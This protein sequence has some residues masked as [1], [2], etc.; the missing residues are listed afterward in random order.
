QSTDD[1][2]DRR[3]EAAA[4]EKE[5]E[6]QEGEHEP[7]MAPA[8]EDDGPDE[9]NAPQ[10]YRSDAGQREAREDAH[11]RLASVPNLVGRTRRTDRWEHKSR[12]RDV[13]ALDLEVAMLEFVER[14]SP[15]NHAPS[16]RSALPIGSPPPLHRDSRT[17]QS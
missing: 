6:R 8:H 3:H 2:E 13:A 5:R 12:R 17:M 10:R 4:E 14:A 7:A 9:G 1:T 15:S 11:H 16:A